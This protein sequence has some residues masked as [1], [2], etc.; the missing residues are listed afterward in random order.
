MLFSKITSDS[1]T[2]VVA[3]VVDSFVVLAVVE[4]EVEVV[5]VDVVLSETFLKTMIPNK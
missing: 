2:C 4:L 1:E 5:V 3:E